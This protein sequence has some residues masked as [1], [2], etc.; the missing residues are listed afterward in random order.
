MRPIARPIARARGSRFIISIT[1]FRVRDLDTARVQILDTAFR[2]S[3]SNFRTRL[4]R[5]LCEFRLE[6]QNVAGGLL[7]IGARITSLDAPDAP[8]PL[9]VRQVGVQGRAAD[10]DL[11]A[12]RALPRETAEISRVVLAEALQHRPMRQAQ[13]PEPAQIE[14]RVT[15]QDAPHKRSMRQTHEKRGGRR[16]KAPARYPCSRKRTRPFLGPLRASPRIS[17]I[18]AFRPSWNR[19]QSSQRP[20]GTSG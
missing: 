12:D 19:P 5:P 20:P 7:P 3:V 14:Q 15:T 4:P 11:L 17:E 10:A 1:I 6:P 9:E 2:I 8:E 13:P 16:N 18:Q